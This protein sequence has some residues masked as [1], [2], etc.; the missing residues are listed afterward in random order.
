[1]CAAERYIPTSEH[2]YRSLTA[3]IHV[4]ETL[5]AMLVALELRLQA[6]HEWV[7][8]GVGINANAVSG[9]SLRASHSVEIARVHGGRGADSCPGYRS[10]HGDFQHCEHSPAA[11]AAVPA[12]GSTGFAERER[13]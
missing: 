6:G 7:A 1:M 5:I 2:P 9:R 11:A 10:E 8:G 13:H 3:L 4:S 12:A